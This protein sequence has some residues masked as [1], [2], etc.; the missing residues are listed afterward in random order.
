[1]IK[2]KSGP[3]FLDPFDMINFRS[4]CFHV[5]ALTCQQ[6]RVFCQSICLQSFEEFLQLLTS[7]LFASP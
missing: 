5:V 2:F 3:I 1:M 4:L 6:V 7:S